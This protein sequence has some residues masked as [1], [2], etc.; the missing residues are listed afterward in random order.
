LLVFGGTGQQGGSVIN[1]ALE[2]SDWWKIRTVTRHP[3]S[4]CAKAL[5]S[6]GVEVIEGDETCPSESL[7]KN[8]YGVFLVTAAWDPSLKGREFEVGKQLVDMAAKMKV[9]HLIFFISSKC[10]R[11]V[12]W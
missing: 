6:R 10:R 4:E 11:R 9:K 2:E 1:A 7:F 12:E 5:C 8:V 3:D